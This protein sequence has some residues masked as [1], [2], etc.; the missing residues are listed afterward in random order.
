MALSENRTLCQPS[1]FPSAHSLAQIL[2]FSAN[3]VTLGLATEQ[4]IVQRISRQLVIVSAIQ[5]DGVA[6]WQESID[7]WTVSCF[8]EIVHVT[9]YNMY[10]I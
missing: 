10:G 2:M 6:E 9:G 5:D 4:L 1:R 8:G 7:A 3:S